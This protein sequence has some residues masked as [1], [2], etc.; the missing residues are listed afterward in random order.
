MF[1][2]LLCFAPL[3][4]EHLQ[5]LSAV[6]LLHCHSDVR[7]SFN[8]NHKPQD[9]NWSFRY[10]LTDS[11]FTQSLPKTS[12]VFSI[13]KGFK[14]KAAAPKQA[15]HFCQI[16]KLFS[17]LWFKLIKVNKKLMFMITT[18]RYPLQV[19]LLTWRCFRFAVMF[20]VDVNVKDLIHWNLCFNMFL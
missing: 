18:D 10:I 5:I 3:S 16:D 9:S 15:E 1:D 20:C 4:Q 17:I 13:R 6:C 7:R 19:G 12:P 8:V 14:H 2:S 11:L